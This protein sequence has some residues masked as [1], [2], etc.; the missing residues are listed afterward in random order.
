[1][2][3]NRPTALQWLRYAFGAKLPDRCDTWV[4]HD[5]TTPTWVLRQIARTL[6]QIAL[7]ITVILVFVP[8]AFWIRAVMVAGGTAIALLFSLSYMTE[9][10]EHRLVKAGYAA[11]TGE[12]LR[13]Q[14][15]A[16]ARTA[17]VTQRRE[18]TAAR[19]AARAHKHA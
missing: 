4:L 11:G 17:A 8:G 9:T 2:T 7:L 19:Q 15:A 1:M 16:T 13:A 12:R 18:R 10:I 6:V 3:S 14:R 5:A